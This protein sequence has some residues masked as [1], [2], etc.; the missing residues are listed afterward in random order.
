MCLGC[1]NV[2]LAESEGFG[3]EDAFGV[4]SDVPREPLEWGE[5]V[6]E[7]LLNVGLKPSRFEFPA[8]TLV[9]PNCATGP[10]SP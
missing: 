10:G 3:R 5:C 9:R 6:P 1:D 4:A 2:M 8:V 7:L